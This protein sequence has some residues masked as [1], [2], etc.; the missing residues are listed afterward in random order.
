MFERKD[1]SQIK[2][3]DPSLAFNEK[4]ACKSFEFSSDSIP[5]WVTPDFAKDEINK[6]TDEKDD[7]YAL[8]AIAYELYNC[9]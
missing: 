1:P 5:T 7:V 9:Q 2:L 4:Q 6:A 3:V 8:G